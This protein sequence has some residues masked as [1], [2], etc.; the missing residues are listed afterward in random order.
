MPGS[1]STIL[2]ALAT[3]DVAFILVGGGAARSS[4]K[5]L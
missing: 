5:Q 3:G 2:R 1:F 4:H